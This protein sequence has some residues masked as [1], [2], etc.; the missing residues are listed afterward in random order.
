MSEWPPA[1]RLGDG[2]PMGRRGYDPHDGPPP[3]RIEREAPPPLPSIGQLRKGQCGIWAHC[4]NIEC[5]HTVPRALAPLI[6][7]WGASASSDLI[8]RSLRCG[9]CGRKGATLTIPSWVDMRI[10]QAPFPV[11]QMG[12][13]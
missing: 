10:G 11:E 4:H 2:E 9:K 5:G 8:R 6:I 1:T 3:K 12:E 13:R 7:R